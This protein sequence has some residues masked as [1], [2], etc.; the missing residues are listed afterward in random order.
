MVLLPKLFSHRK[1]VNL[2][3]CPPAF[4]IPHLVKLPMVPA[5]ERDGEFIADLETEL[6][7]VQTAD[8][9]NRRVGARR[10]GRVVRQRISGVPCRAGALVL[11][12][13][14]GSC[15]FCR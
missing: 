5:T 13:R 11:Q 14:V 12:W 10:L 4:F 2:I 6:A 1:Y 15:R 9:A 3:F 7:I 8:D